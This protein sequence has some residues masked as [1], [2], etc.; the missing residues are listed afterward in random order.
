MEIGDA[1][2][3]RN[4]GG[5]ASDDALRSLIIS[6]RLLGT[7]EYAV[8]H[9]TDCGMLTFSN[10]DLQGKLAADTG[11]DASHMDF[12][13]FSDLEESVRDD[14]RRIRDDPYIPADIEVSGWVYDVKTGELREIVPVGR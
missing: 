10:D 3:I 4:A 1:H 5:R 8:I 12:L 7:Q 9:H 6:S 11:R 2:V 13:P 14:V